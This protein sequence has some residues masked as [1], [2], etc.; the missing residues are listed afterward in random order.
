MVIG[1][2]QKYSHPK[3]DAHRA[4]KKMMCGSDRVKDGAV[5]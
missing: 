5:N 2:P 4:M 3:A 1:G